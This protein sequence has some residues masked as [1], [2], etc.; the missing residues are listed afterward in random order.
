MEHELEKEASDGLSF[1]DLLWPPPVQH[2]LLEELFSNHNAVA[3]VA[4][5]D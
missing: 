3:I 5:P 1:K 2:F 4:P